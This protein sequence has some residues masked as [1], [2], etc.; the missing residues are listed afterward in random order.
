MYE[1]MISSGCKTDR[2]TNYFQGA[3]KEDQGLAT[4]EMQEA[5]R[6]SPDMVTHNTLIIKAYSYLASRKRP[7]LQIQR[8]LVFQFIQ[9]V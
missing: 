7:S 2:W 1:E 4:S 6:V 9:I 3:S 8:Y 5:A